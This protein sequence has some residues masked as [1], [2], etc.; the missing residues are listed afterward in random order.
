MTGAIGHDQAWTEWRD[1]LAGPRLHHGWILSGRRGIG[2]AGFALAAAR[3]LVAVPGGQMPGAH[4]DIVVLEPLPANPDEEKKRDEGRPYLRKR[5]IGVDQVRAMQARLTT[6]PTLGP[7][8]AIIIDAADD[9]E[10]S[11]ANAL[12]KSL[13][14]PPVGT[15]FL[16][17]AHRLGGLLPT[18]RSRCRILHFRPLTA[19][20]IDAVLH[21]AAP[22]ASAEERAAAIAAAAGS[23]G[24]ALDFVSLD[25]AAMHALMVEIAR[26]GDADLS[27]RGRLGEA[28]GARPERRRQLAAI[29]LA[30]AIVAE[31]LRDTPRGQLPVL[32]DTH[33]RLVQ[34]GAEAPTFN[35]D[36]GLL[37][38]EIGGLLARIADPRDQRHG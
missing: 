21:Q 25:L 37:V 14:E 20:Q 10:R 28:M 30:R 26:T 27:R 9:L 1:A 34:L 35:F 38:L 13:E 2:K 19:V 3:E 31:R 5:S 24:V 12:L 6:R 8:R 17:V 15:H 7:R 16:L 11:A 36:P 22:E 4:P 32:A 23:P 33:A 18:I 29:D